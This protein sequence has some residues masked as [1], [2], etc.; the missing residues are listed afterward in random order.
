MIGLPYQYEVTHFH[1]HCS[2]NPNTLQWNPKYTAVRFLGALFPGQ[3]EGPKR[4]LGTVFKTL[5]LVFSFKSI[6]RPYNQHK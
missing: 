6:S 2:E 5:I 1:F 3:A 4:A